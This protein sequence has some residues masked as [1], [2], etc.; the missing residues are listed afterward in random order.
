MVLVLVGNVMLPRLAV[1]SP[2]VFPTPTVDVVPP[3]VTLLLPPVLKSAA[4]PPVVPVLVTVL[5]N[6]LVLDWVRAAVFV[7]VL[8]TVF[9]DTAP[10]FVILLSAAYACV[11]PLR[12]NSAP[13]ITRVANVILNVFIPHPLPR[14]IAILVFCE[15]NIRRVIKGL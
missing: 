10:L 5:A 13:A 1:L 4:F 12:K 3:V 7:C 2:D 15:K 11:E 9:D 14:N 6:V 8:V